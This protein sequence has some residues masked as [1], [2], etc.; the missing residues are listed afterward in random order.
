MEEP[1]VSALQSNLG[2]LHYNF[3]YASN[4]TYYPFVF[5]LLL[6]LTYLKY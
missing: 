1:L 4:T 5:K 3:G 6:L 2:F